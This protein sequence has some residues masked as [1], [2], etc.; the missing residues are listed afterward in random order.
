[1][2]RVLIA[3]AGGGLGRAW[4]E[5]L[6]RPGTSLEPAFPGP[7]EVVASPRAELDIS[8]SPGSI[9]AV[10]E[11]APDLVLNCAGRTE[12]QFCES[13][14]GEAMKVNRDGA[15]HVAKACSELGA[16]AVYFST[17]LVFDGGKGIPY[18]EGDPPNPLNAYGESKLAGEVRTLSYATRYLIVRSGWVYGHAGRHFLRPFQEGLL[19]GE[20]LRAL[21]RQTG[22]ATWIGDFMEA[23]LHLLRAGRTGYYHVASGAPVTQMDV[24]RR[25][26]ELAGRPDLRLEGWGRDLLPRLPEYTAL[27]CGRLAGSGWSMRPWEEGAADFVATRL[28]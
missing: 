23:V 24:L 4:T 1:M 7:V 27:D 5:R 20:G 25:V 15:E 10:R 12:L 19:R 16:L 18:V 28:A 3:G 8:E 22:Q 9:R 2:V 11:A 26:A 14:P 17:D 21:D 6:E 13:F